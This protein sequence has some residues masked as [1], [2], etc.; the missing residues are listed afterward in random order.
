MELQLVYVVAMSVEV[1]L[2]REFHRL[3]CV[4]KLYTDF[5][6]Y[7]DGCHLRKYARNCIRKDLTPTSVRLAK[8]E[9]VIDK[10]HLAGH[11]DKWCLANCNPHLFP[12]L[13]KVGL[14]FINSFRSVHC[15]LGG[16]RSV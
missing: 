7:D 4:S 5:I 9:I 3:Y 2:R 16:H 15:N 1:E 13:E 11:I 12:Q 8:I 6:C 10:M 14:R